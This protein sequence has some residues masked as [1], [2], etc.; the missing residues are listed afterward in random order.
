[1]DKDISRQV[2]TLERAIEHW[3]DDG[4]ENTQFL[5]LYSVCM[6]KTMRKQKRGKTERVKTYKTLLLF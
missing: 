4:R 1:M 3:P 6:E 2:C 5:E